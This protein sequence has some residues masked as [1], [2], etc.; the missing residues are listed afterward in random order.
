MGIEVASV[1]ERGAGVKSLKYSE[2]HC[3]PHL[4]RA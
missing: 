4:F 2:E 1:I 3:F